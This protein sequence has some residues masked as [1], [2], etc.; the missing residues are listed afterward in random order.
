MRI[1]VKSDSFR[2]FL[3][4]KYHNIF[5]QVSTK[6]EQINVVLLYTCRVHNKNYAL[7]FIIVFFS[8]SCL[9]KDIYCMFHIFTVLFI[10]VVF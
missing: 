3:T 5:R 1:V 6:E 2:R 10:S 7:L 8:A 9:F 4:L